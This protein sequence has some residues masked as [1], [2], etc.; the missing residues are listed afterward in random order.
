MSDLLAELGINA[1][2]T[3]AAAVEAEASEAEKQTR[4]RIDVGVI[5]IGEEA[6]DLPDVTRGG[7][8]PR[9]V[10]SKYK[11]DDI[12]APVAKEDGS[13]YR[14]FPMTVLVGD[15]DPEAFKRSVASANTQ[16]NA[17]WKEEGRKFV[18][19]SVNDAEGK[20]AGVKVYR[21]DATQDAAA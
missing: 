3:T 2:E 21:V 16:A 14:Y 12:P 20:Y 6:E 11:F 9:N 15:N 10:T 17:K 8:G 19:R 18:V 5:T 13:G 1:D 7:F 4:Q